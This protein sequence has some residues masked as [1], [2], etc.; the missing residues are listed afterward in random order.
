MMFAPIFTLAEANALVPYIAGEVARLRQA[1]VRARELD[2]RK[3]SAPAT[4]APA[5]TPAPVAEV[6]AAAEREERI[7]IEADVTGAIQALARAG[8]SV[9]LDPAGVDVAA[10]HNGHRVRLHW[11]EGNDEFKLWRDDAGRLHTID[12]AEAFGVAIE[13]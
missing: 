10:D 6:E 4:N 8:V 13:Q 12:E 5:S 7:A 1:I 3:K 2:E 11:V 9:R